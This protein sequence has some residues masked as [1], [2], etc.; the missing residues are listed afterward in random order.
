MQYKT[1]VLELLEQS[2]GLSRELR[3]NDALLSTM[4]QLAVSFRDLHLRLL[5]QLTSSQPELDENQLKYQAMEVATEQMQ[6]MI[7]QAEQLLS[8][9]SV[10]A[11]AC[12]VLL[13]ADNR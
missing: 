6:E 2:P 1:I 12:L 10:S 9:G 3:R 7:G 13:Q 4:N 8:N 11:E 5:D